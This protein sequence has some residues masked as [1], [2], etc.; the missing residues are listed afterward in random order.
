MSVAEIL[1]WDDVDAVT[2]G[3]RGL[4]KRPWGLMVTEQTSVARI[5]LSRASTGIVVEG[6]DGIY[7]VPNNDNALMSMFPSTL[8]EEKASGRISCRSQ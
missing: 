7:R 2:I 4:S 6:N 3:P 8:I 1:F 5:V